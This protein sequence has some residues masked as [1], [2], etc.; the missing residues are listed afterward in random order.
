MRP[1][2]CGPD[3]GLHERRTGEKILD[4]FCPSLNVVEKFNLFYRVSEA[5]QDRQ[6]KYNNTKAWLDAKT[7]VGVKF[8][9]YKY[10]TRIK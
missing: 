9:V 1:E 2:I 6:Q 7:R 8:H 10:I 3:R 5:R 4:G